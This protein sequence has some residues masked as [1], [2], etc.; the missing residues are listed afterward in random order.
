[1]SSPTQRA[2]RKKTIERLDL[3][4]TLPETV[5]T[6]RT[7]TRSY[8]VRVAEYPHV[9]TATNGQKV[10]NGISVRRE[11]TSSERIQMNIPFITK[12]DIHEAYHGPSEFP[13]HAARDVLLGLPWQVNGE[14]TGPV[15][16]ITVQGQLRI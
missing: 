3:Y 1:M 14:H 11:Y 8:R 2:D 9:F 4:Y 12:E 15:Q 7:T 6:I 5:V 13:D 16:E 10:I